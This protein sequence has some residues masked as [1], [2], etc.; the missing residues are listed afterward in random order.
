M[1][2]HKEQLRLM[3]GRLNS[4]DLESPLASRVLDSYS[5]QLH[6]IS[7]QLRKSK[8]SNY[9]YQY[10]KD[11]SEKKQWQSTELLQ[12]MKSLSNAIEDDIKK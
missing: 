11:L 8:S 3:V 10:L 9:I 1:N 4:L 2:N 12:A 5:D 6:E 7:E